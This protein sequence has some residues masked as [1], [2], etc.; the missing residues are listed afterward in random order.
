MSDFITGILLLGALILGLQF[1]LWLL[2]RML[3]AKVFEWLTGKFEKV[4]NIKRVWFLQVLMSGLFLKALGD[5]GYVFYMR[6]RWACLLC[7]GLLIAHSL[8]NNRKGWAIAFGL[9][10]IIYTPIIPLHLDRGTWT[11][12]NIVS[13]VVTLSSIMVLKENKFE[14]VSAK[15]AGPDKAANPGKQL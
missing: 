14:A 2:S 7:F 11:L 1:V 5:N 12:I 3:P 8:A 13:I 10:T 9:L 4:L 6:L 15:I